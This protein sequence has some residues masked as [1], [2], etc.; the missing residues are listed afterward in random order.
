MNDIVEFLKARLDEDA[1]IALA[2][3]D[4]DGDDTGLE[5]AFVNLT[6]PGATP[7]L[8]GA[9]NDEFAAM[10]VRH[11]VP[12]RALREVEAK[13]EIIAFHE[14]WPVLTKT[15]PKFEAMDSGD[16]NQITYRMSQQV[17][18]LTTQEYVAKFGREPPTAPILLALAAVY[19]DH[20]NYRDEWRAP[21]A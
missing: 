8:R 7:W 20:P 1:A 2:M 19:A 6:T 21:I 10:L 3:I 12:A 18:W 15:L 4:E 11:V 13:R 5:G 16:I 9:L 17:G 14:Q